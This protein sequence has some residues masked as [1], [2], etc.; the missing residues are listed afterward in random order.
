MSTSMVPV[1]EGS[2]RSS[3]AMHPSVEVNTGP[4]LTSAWIGRRP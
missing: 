1:I 4:S 3:V 2:L